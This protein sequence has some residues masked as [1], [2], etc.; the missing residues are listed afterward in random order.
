MLWSFTR[1]MTLVCGC[2]AALTLVPSARSVE[3]MRPV[4]SLDEVRDRLARENSSWQ[5]G[6]TSVSE[7]PW[8]V[9]E[10]RLELRLPDD[11][12]SRPTRRPDLPREA[13][14]VLPSR[15]DWR[16]RGGVTPVKD[17]GQCGSCW[18]FASIGALE[19]CAVIHDLEVYDLSEQQMISCNPQGYGC[20][21]GDMEACYTLFADPGAI[22]E[23]AMPY[24]MSDLASCDMGDSEPLARIES[25]FYLDHAVESIK[26]AIISYGP[27]VSAMTVYPDFR[28]YTSGCYE[29]PRSGMVNHAVVIVGW[30]DELCDGAWIV[31]NSWGEAWGD[32]GYFAIRYGH[33]DIG[34][35]AAALVH[36]PRA[37]ITF[38]HLPI[39]TTTHVGSPV[40]ISSR[41]ESRRGAI[42][43]DSVR[44]FFRV[45]GETSFQ[46]LP[47]RFDPA[48][49]LWQGELPAIDAPASIAYYFRASD[50]IGPG[51]CCPREAP[52]ELFTF[53]VATYYAGFDHGR[54]GWTA[55]ADG[56]DAVRGVWEWAAPVG[57]SIQ[58]GTDRRPPNGACWITGQHA[59]GTEAGADD[60]DDGKTTLTSPPYDLR[61]VRAAQV[62][63]WRWYSNDRGAGAGEDTWIVEASMNG[64]P[65]QSIE[66]TR[67]S[68]NAWVCVTRDLADV[69]GPVLGSVVFRF[70]A[71]DEGAPSAVEAALDD[72]TILAEQDHGAALSIEEGDLRV[73]V[74]SPNPFR[75]ESRIELMANREIAIE[76]VVRALDGRVIRVLRSRTSLE[77]GRHVLFWDGRD[78]S[79]RLAPSGVYPCVAT[80]DGRR[81]RWNLALV[82]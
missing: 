25:W 47:L 15:W 80:V 65:W 36:V 13:G 64:G 33:A 74:P 40:P 19:G 75:T 32:A 58:P 12:A 52:Q 60:V 29:H 79:G 72:V 18:A 2:L 26:A 30:D 14:D 51:V 54:E 70:V 8:D 66:R 73:G 11:L 4:E 38:D 57:S 43:A 77:R 55:G 34:T 5:A 45:E 62:K 63:Y 71:S 22:A 21:G 59:E 69:F 6:I 48:T 67:E 56:D 31:K 39:E 10:E 28:Y 68:S 1:T 24:L 17:Q 41:I 27:V 7:I 23:E 9:F 3:S 76:A 53:D 37:S 50:G 16:E 44:L 81:L 42:Q 46:G 35:A 20:D 82:R 78:A 61:G 49:N